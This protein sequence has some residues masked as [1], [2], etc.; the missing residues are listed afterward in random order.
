M[1][2]LL[3]SGHFALVSSVSS[4]GQER[5]FGPRQINVCFAPIA[6][7]IP[8][9]ECFRLIRSRFCLNNHPR[10]LLGQ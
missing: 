8:R 7:I 6:D 9:R 3:R 5:P 10:N 4:S 1:S 2:A